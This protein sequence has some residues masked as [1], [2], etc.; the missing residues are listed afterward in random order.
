[1]NN[2]VRQGGV[3]SGIFFVVYIDKLLKLLRNS[4]LGCTIH[5]V[6]FGGFI[7]ADDIFLLSASRNGLQVMVDISQSFASDMNLRFGTN[8]NIEKSKTKCILFTKNKRLMNN[9]KELALDDHALPWVDRVTHLGHTVQ[10]DNSM[11][12]DINMK[13]GSFIGKVNSLLQE[14]H[15]ASPEVLIKLIVNNLFQRQAA[16]CNE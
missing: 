15:Y 9:A 16:L 2:G 7:Y 3:C 10:A 11:A 6:F 14:F 8:A 4:G 5:G 13:K 12:I 1:M